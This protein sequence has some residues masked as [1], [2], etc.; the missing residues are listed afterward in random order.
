MLNAIFTFGYL[1]VSTPFHLLLIQGGLGVAAAMATPTWNALYSE[2]ENK[3]KD[4]FQWGLSDGFSVLATGVA[5]IIGGFIVVYY[6]FTTLF[7]MM[8]IIQILAVIRIVPI[9]KIK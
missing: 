6:S 4:G 3:R 7:I 1:F 8:G 2:H 9:L 5:I